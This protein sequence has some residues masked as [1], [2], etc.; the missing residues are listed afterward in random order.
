[1]GRK[2]KETTVE[3]RKIAMRLYNQCKS[4]REVGDIIGRPHSTVQSSI[5]QH[6]HTNTVHKMPQSGRP[7]KVMGHR[8]RLLL[9]IVKE[10]PRTSAPKMAEAMAHNGESVSASTVRRVQRTC[11]AQEFLRF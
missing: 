3:E 1:M 11:G 7:R 10:N 6:W 9:R 2:G 8:E 5:D 4:L